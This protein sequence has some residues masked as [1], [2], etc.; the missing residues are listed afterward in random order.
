MAVYTKINK[1]DISIINNKFYIEKIVSFQGIKEGIENTN[2]LLIFGD[3][4]KEK[5]HA[6]LIPKQK[7]IRIVYI[8]NCDHNTAKKLKKQK[9][10]YKII[11]NFFK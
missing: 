8:K 11:N 10:L 7:N 5:Y 3:D 2:Y 4:D 6:S 1:K 9:E